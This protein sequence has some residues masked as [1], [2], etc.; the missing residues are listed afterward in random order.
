MLCSYRDEIRGEHTQVQG[1][2]VVRADGLAREPVRDTRAAEAVA[3]RRAQR[4]Y[5]HLRADG[6]RQ[7]RRHLFVHARCMRHAAVRCGVGGARSCNGSDL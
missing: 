7:R 1:L 5:V 6:A 3:A 2:A 4:R